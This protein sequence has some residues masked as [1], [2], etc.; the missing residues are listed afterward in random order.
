MSQSD[1]SISNVSRSLFRTENNEALQA[2][3]SLSSD[4]TEPATTYPFQLWADTSTGVLKQRN[5]ANN[6]WISL[7]VLASGGLAQ[8]GGMNLTGSINDKRST[9]AATATTTPLWDVGSGNIQDWTGTPTITDFPEAPQPGA[10]RWSYPAAGTIITDNSNIDV[11]GDANYTVVAGDRIEV[12]ALTVSTFKVFIKKK[13]GQAVSGASFASSAEYIAGT[14]LTKALNSATAREAN[15]VLG[16]P[17]ATTSGTSHDFTGLPSWVK[18]FFVMFSGLSTNGSSPPIFQLGDSGGI[19]P[20]AYLG[21]ASFLGATTGGANFTTGFGMNSSHSA[22]NVYHG[23]AEF[24]LLDAAT[25]TWTYSM[26]G[27]YSNAGFTIFGGGS[28]SLSGTLD[29]VRLT[30]VNG[31]DTFDNGLIEIS[32]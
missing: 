23:R 1:L 19:E 7:Y 18:R 17:I 29:R 4:A 30:T 15:I 25:N 21:S 8:L 14:D 10:R 3:A 12:E 6:G 28:K 16:T 9:V 24:R 2:L 26:T 22:V 27:A 32:Y 5:A 11:E 13:N 20:T 31:S